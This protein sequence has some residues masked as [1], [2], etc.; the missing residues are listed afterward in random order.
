MKNFVF[1]LL[2]IITISACQQSNQ[3][4]LRQQLT[5]LEKS[6]GGAAVSDRSKAT[7]FIATAEKLATELQKN[8]PDEYVD[9]L[10]KT[11]GLAKTIEDPNKAI[12]LYQ[13]IMANMPQHKRASTAMFMTG[14]IYAN[15]LGQLGK[16]KETYEAFLQKYPN[17]ELAESAKMEL[18]NLGKSPEELIKQF[19]QQNK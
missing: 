14:F 3:D 5:E 12:A 11:A 10:L 4:K 9:L 2:L 16:A 1:Y 6:M 18:A 15:D 17:D 19:E 7:E 8:N 13:N